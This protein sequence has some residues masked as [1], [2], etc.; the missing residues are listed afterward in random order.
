MSTV[1]RFPPLTAGSWTSFERAALNKLWDSYRKFPRF[2]VRLDYATDEGDPVCSFV[3][4]DGT[5]QIRIAKRRGA[6]VVT[7][8]AGA[9][10]AV[11][12]RGH[13]VDDLCSALLCGMTALPDH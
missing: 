1:V 8:E 5:A 11:I 12:Y 13:S 2:P 10:S 7:A 3:R 9:E 4:H 6:Y